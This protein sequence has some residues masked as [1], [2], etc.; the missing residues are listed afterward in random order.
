[1]LLPENH[2]PQFSDCTTLES[3]VL[4]LAREILEA[5]KDSAINTANVELIDIDPS[6]KNEVIDIK[7]SNW[8]ANW[9]NGLIVINNPFPSHTFTTGTGTYPFNQATLVNAFFH[10]AMFLHKNELSVSKNIASKQCVEFDITSVNEIGDPQQLEVSVTITELPITI[11]NTP[12][13]TSSS[14]K[15]YLV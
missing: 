12:T 14:A 15:P 2:Y 5:Q 7:T 11:T 4:Q 6:E 13:S 10:V 1:M 8:T 9:N 3:L